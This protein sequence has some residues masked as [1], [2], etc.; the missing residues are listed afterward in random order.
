M[1]KKVKRG[2]SQVLDLEEE[3]RGERIEERREVG[4]TVRK[5]EEKNNVALKLSHNFFGEI[6]TCYI[7][8]PAVKWLFYVF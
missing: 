1:V 2:T 6:L 4:L 3:R 5:K 8:A 7:R